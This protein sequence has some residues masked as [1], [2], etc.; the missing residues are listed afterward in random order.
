MLLDVGYVLDNVLLVVGTAV[1]VVLLKQLLTT[2]VVLSLGHSLVTSLVS[3]LSLAQVGEFSFVLASVGAPLGLFASDHY[4]LF[5]T[6]SVLTMLATP[7]LIATARP[8]ADRFARTLG[9]TDVLM[10]APEEASRLSQLSDH[11]VIVGYGLS[12]RHL[13]RVLA[14]AD[15]AHVVL[16]QNGRIVREARAAGVPILYGD[17][18]RR[19]VLERV[20]LSRAR[21]VVFVIS[22]PADE[23]RGVATAHDINPGIR[24]VVRTRYVRSIDELM[25]LGASEV[26]VEEYEATIELFARVLE[27]YEIP[28]YTIHRELEAIRAEHYQL[29]RREDRPS[30]ALDALRHLGIHRAL[31]MMEVEEGS[32]AVGE[33]PTSLELRRTTGAVVIAVVRDGKAI[34]QRD[35]NFA[36]RPGDIVVAV[37]ERESLGRTERLFRR[38]S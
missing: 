23:R 12:G 28:T 19:E 8:L 27:G 30:L 36:F 13:Q 7:A 32:E 14:A 35:P 2:A 17:G 9:L 4:Q 34:Y 21:V 22:S 26:V 5:L 31:D 25:R 3:G 38:A 6:A 24:H 29:F 1:A 37:G 18:T 16:E 20:G 33:S 10:P 11:A 15:I